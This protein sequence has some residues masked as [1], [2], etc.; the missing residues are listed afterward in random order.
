MSINPK[1]IFEHSQIFDLLYKENLMVFECSKIE[2]FRQVKAIIYAQLFVAFTITKLKKLY[3][4]TPTHY[5]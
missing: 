3:K 4:Q 2:D 1:R 5:P